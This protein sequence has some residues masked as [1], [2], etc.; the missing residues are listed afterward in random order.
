MFSIHV[1]YRTFFRRL[2]LKLVDMSTVEH[3]FYDSL[4]VQFYNMLPLNI[5]REQWSYWLL[6]AYH[7]TKV[8]TNTL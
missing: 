6:W 4:L 3:N 7:R 8:Y 1:S 2:T 5:N